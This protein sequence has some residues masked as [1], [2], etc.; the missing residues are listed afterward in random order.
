MTVME[1][2]EMHKNRK[3][4]P[5]YPSEQVVQYIFRNFKRDGKEKILDLGC[6][7]GRHTLFM[8]NENIIPYGIDYSES[9]VYY[10]KENLDENGYS[11]YKDN[12]V[13]ADVTNLPFQDSFFDGVISYGVLYYIGFD[14]IKKA[15]EEIFRVL[16][17]NGRAF[18]VVRSTEDYRAK[19]GT[20]TEEH[21]S[22][23]V[24]EDNSE[25]CAS[26]E[27]GMLMH[28]FDR[29]EIEQLFTSF[30][31]LTIDLIEET[32]DNETFKDSNYLIRVSKGE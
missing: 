15:V 27:N 6:G 25:K 13:V 14:Q 18:I 3:F 28:F 23:I 19:S 2:N 1:W 7:A 26:N 16:K 32:H 11:G 20:E 4:R 8:A 29:D 30:S 17:P 10:T 21:N 9:G 12:I 22:L 31:S 24:N 5:K